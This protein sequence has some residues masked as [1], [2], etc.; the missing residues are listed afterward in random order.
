MI[1][2]NIIRKTFLCYSHIVSISLQWD[3]VCEDSWKGPFTTSMFFVGVFSGS[4]ASGHLSDRYGRKFI[5][6]ATMA[7]Q[8]VFSLVQVFS[9]SWEMFCTLYFFVGLGQISN[10]VAAFILGT[11]L[12][13]KSAGAVHGTL[14]N[15]LFYA[16]GYAIMP[17]LAYFI[18]DWR[19]LLLAMTLPGFLYVP[20]WWF[21][22]ESP[23]WLLS[24]GRVEEAEAIVQAAA[25][26]NG[27]TYTGVIFKNINSST[28]MLSNP[29]H[30]IKRTYTY[31]DLV[32]DFNLRINTVVSCFMWIIISTCYFGISLNTS[33]MN[34]DPYINCL[35]SAASEIV[36]YIFAWWL[37]KIAHRRM[38]NVSMMLLSGTMLLL[39][40][41]V[42]SALHIV[43][44]VLAMIGKFCITTVFAVIYIYSAELFPT[45]VRNMG[46]GACSMASRFGSVVS[47]YIVYLGRFN[48]ELPFI[49]MGLLMLVSVVL[50]CILP[51]THKQPLP[52]TIEQTQ[53]PRCCAIK[54]NKVVIAENDEI[55]EHLNLK[56]F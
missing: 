47:P 2:R 51:E 49:L 54:R 46:L 40:Q 20:L 3:L 12:L 16:L 42:P 8:T 38:A 26:Q 50:S 27:I 30:N 13:S 10:Y 31:F 55:P 19:M 44:T 33:N 32:K 11:E 14:G 28:D 35:I 52:D 41:L 25:K 43:F 36:A 39:I 22:P 6:F 56:E 24:K 4:F 15:C 23:R 37:L 7:L 9:V 5:L 1:R 45:V 29:K 53:P 21:I 48:K 17:F 34:G 18:R